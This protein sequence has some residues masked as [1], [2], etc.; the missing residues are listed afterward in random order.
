MLMRAPFHGSS[1]YFLVMRRTLRSS[2]PANHQIATTNVNASS[3]P[4]ALTGLP[5]STKSG[6]CSQIGSTLFIP[7]SS[8]RHQSRLAS[9]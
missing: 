9:W 2:A 8:I 7:W 3:R 1:V 6:C 4:T 5:P